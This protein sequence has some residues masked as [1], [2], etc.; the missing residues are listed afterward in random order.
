M[1]LFDRYI[2]AMKQTIS[3]TD[4][5]VMS[6]T[7]DVEVLNGLQLSHGLS[8]D[9]N[10]I[11]PDYGGGYGGYKSTLSSY[12]LTGSTPDLFLTGK[13]Y[14]SIQAQIKGDNVFIDAPS[15]SYAPDLQEKYG[16]NILNLT[17]GSQATYRTG[18]Y[19]QLS[20]E[21]LKIWK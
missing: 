16:K 3:A 14:K 19:K 1:A 6:S 13:F 11:T 8:G 7:K 9:G 18:L 15:L 20:T 4:K 21:Y 17:K 10:P 2:T 5:V 12:G